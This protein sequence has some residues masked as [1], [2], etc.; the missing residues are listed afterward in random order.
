ME[1]LILDKDFAELMKGFSKNSKKLGD[2]ENAL[3]Y[4]E[5]AKSIYYAL[6]GDNKEH[7]YEYSYCMLEIG[8]IYTKVGRHQEAL[9]S[10]HSVYDRFKYFK[11]SVML[12]E[13][14][15]SISACQSLGQIYRSLGKY[16]EANEYFQIALDN[17]QKIFKN[18]LLEV[19]STEFIYQEA[20]S[21]KNN[22]DLL[23]QKGNFI[24]AEHLMNESIRMMENVSIKNIDKEDVENYNNKISEIYYYFLRMLI[25]Q[26]RYKDCIII[27]NK[28]E[29][30]IKTYFDKNS[31]NYFNRLALFH[32]QCGEYFIIIKDYINS[33]KHHNKELKNRILLF[34]SSK[35][36]VNFRYGLALC[37]KNLGEVYRLQDK[38]EKS[39]KYYLKYKNIIKSLC[40][41]NADRID[42]QNELSLC[43]TKIACFVESLQ[44][45][46]RHFYYLYKSLNIAKLSIQKSKNFF[47]KR[48]LADSYYNLSHSYREIKNFSKSIIYSKKS[49]KLYSTNLDDKDSLSGYID[50]LRITI[51]NLIDLDFTEMVKFK[52]LKKLLEISNNTQAIFNYFCKEIISYFENVNTFNLVQLQN[53]I[54][55]LEYFCNEFILSGKYIPVNNISIDIINILIYLYNVS[56]ENIKNKLKNSKNIQLDIKNFISF[57]MEVIKGKWIL[58][59][60]L[61]SDD[62]I[63]DLFNDYLII[64]N[65]FKY[66]GLI[67]YAYE[68]IC[69]AER[70]ILEIMKSLFEDYTDISMY[71]HI[72]YKLYKNIKSEKHNIEQYLQP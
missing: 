18:N 54:H 14:H 45:K 65:D 61:K 25:V 12:L 71:V 3:S 32:K 27:I 5:S 30:I 2:L 29:K 7:E 8:D 56:K 21:L 26:K 35:K 16:D 1:N 66:M 38:I 47:F 23:F 40:M 34:N 44:N 70:A 24:E 13:R 52:Y 49:A 46:K 60:I 48:N 19:S 68:L 36:D 22:A 20:I 37:C 53:H 10:I 62:S 31:T 67:E 55:T 28:Q 17:S 72:T 59:N 43:Y 42:F 51:S 41:D 57:S 11:D 58:Y 50:S 63:F 64:S 4:F 15:I 33:E 69:E 9:V 39:K 6:M